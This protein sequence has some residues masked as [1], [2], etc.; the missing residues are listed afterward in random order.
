MSYNNYGIVNFYPHS[1][2][3]PSNQS[4]NM[5]WGL[6][7]MESK[8]NSLGSDL[9]LSED[10]ISDTTSSQSISNVFKNYDNQFKE[11]E[12]RII[13]CRSGERRSYLKPE[14]LKK[15]LEPYRQSLDASDVQKFSDSSELKEDSSLGQPSST[16]V[17]PSWFDIQYPSECS[18]TT[19]ADAFSIHPL[20]IEDC[21]SDSE[22]DHEKIETFENY[23]FICFSEC[24]LVPETNIIAT[25]NVH[26]IL[27]FTA[28]VVFSLHN[29]YVYYL[30]P[31]INNIIQHSKN[32]QSVSADHEKSQLLV[33]ECCD[34][35]SPAWITYL[36]LDA[37]VD[38][39]FSLVERC[40][41]E[42]NFI[43]ELILLLDSQEQTDLLRRIS[44][45]QK[46]TFNLR[47]KLV[48]KQE[49]L[50]SMVGRTSWKGGGG[51]KG[52]GQIPETTGRDR[53]F[54]LSKNAFG[55]SLS[56]LESG[57][58]HKE[59]HSTNVYIRDILD[60]V[61]FMLSNLEQARETV[62]HLTHTYLAKVSIEINM[63]ANEQNDVMKKF[64]AMATVILPLT[65]V[66]S[67]WGMNVYVP[68]QETPGYLP[69][70]GITGTLIVIGTIAFI[71]FW[72]TWI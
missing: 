14:Y 43:D 1:N 36:I 27:L 40:V 60:H 8:K 41:M 65:F 59:A 70:F 55:S 37:I 19:I 11:K 56:L 47:T 16:Y 2:E 39:F 67:L 33:S 54:N 45:C 35:V 51:Q 22:C 34:I 23:Q 66:A 57:G 30:R 29:G 61:S 52:F 15:N 44:A 64:S 38:E 72:K 69:F 10:D 25:V 28:P 31:T 5:N 42:A 21:L 48:R 17:A 63:T 62:A 7:N 4:D 3:I 50:S 53:L 9:N 6:L 49:I 12:E 46:Q 68:F 26:I 13:F 18:M 20:T 58:F 71:Y 32:S 24:Y